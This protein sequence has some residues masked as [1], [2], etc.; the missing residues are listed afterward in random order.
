MSICTGS[1]FIK[2]ASFSVAKPYWGQQVCVVDVCLH[3]SHQHT[4]SALNRFLVLAALIQP[5]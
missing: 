4:L 2:P 3:H 1:I 5:A